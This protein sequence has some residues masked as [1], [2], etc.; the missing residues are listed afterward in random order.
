MLTERNQF[1]QQCTQGKKQQQQQKQN[2]GKIRDVNKF[3]C[4]V[5][6]EVRKVAQ[7]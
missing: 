5:K 6:G 2:I 3:G 7:F 1:K 4:W